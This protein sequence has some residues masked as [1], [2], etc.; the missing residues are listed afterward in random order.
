MHIYTEATDDEIARFRSQM[1]NKIGAS[2]ENEEASVQ[3]SERHGH[4]QVQL[5]CAT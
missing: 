4:V 1:N 3:I 5:M 2:G